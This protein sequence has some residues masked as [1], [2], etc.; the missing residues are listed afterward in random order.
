MEP[1]AADNVL[2]VA[3]KLAGLPFT[4]RCLNTRFLM[5]STSQPRQMD[6][7]V[8]FLRGVCAALKSGKPVQHQGDVLNNPGVRQML[9]L[10]ALDLRGQQEH[11]HIVRMPAMLLDLVDSALRRCDLRRGERRKTTMQSHLTL[12]LFLL[13]FAVSI[14]LPFHRQA[15]LCHSGMY[16]SSARHRWHIDGSWSLCSWRTLS[17]L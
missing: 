5:A 11:S 8:R 3:S 17:G 15:V 14:L 1:G 9:Q 7:S 4:A 6:S 2:P 10:L 16:C 12:F 13:T